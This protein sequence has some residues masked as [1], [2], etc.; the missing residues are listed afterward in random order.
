MND[1]GP[2]PGWQNDILWQ[3]GRPQD[4]DTL[5]FFLV[6]QPGWLYKAYLA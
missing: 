3:P 5:F 1:S 2:W 4:D 6:A